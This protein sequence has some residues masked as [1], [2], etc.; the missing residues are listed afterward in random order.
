MNKIDLTIYKLTNIVNTSDS[1]SNDTIIAKALLSLRNEIDQWTLE[2]IAKKYYVSQPSISRFIRKLGFDGFSAFKSALRNSTYTVE[3]V[4]PV[5]QKEFKQAT[6]DI[7]K[8]LHQIIEG[9]KLLKEEDV[10]DV[11]KIMMKHENIYFIG[12]E[13][14]MAIVRLL[15]VKL[16]ALGKNVYTLYKNSYQSEIMK[17]TTEKDL[18]IVLSMGQRWYYF[19]GKEH[20]NKK[21]KENRMLWTVTD[22][23]EDMD[24]FDEI[25]MI[26]NT[27]DAN[28]GYH[29]L[30][31]YVMLLYQMM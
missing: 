31:Q 19:L 14:S 3:Y 10:R 28:L 12:S 18:V 25:V 15:Q 17:R 30:M 1:E 23:H 4:N 20:I 5:I 11:I 7:Y 13:L 21:H 22:E 26:G 9:I 6:D 29:Y 27:K 8:D 16:I 2:E 24:Y